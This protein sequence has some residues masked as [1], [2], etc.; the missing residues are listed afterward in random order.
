MLT[1]LEKVDLLRKSAMFCDVPTPG[2]ARVAAIA[3][4]ITFAPNQTLYVEDTVADSMFFLLEGEVE[5]V[6][7][8]GKI[9]TD[10]RGQVLGALALLSDETY[11]ESAQATQPTQVLRIDRQ[12]FF[13]TMAE[14]FD[15]T[16]GVLKALASVAAGGSRSHPGPRSL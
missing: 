11:T 15:V 1:V 9:G 4:A 16:R 3:S 10:R 12:E 13:D 6:H 5:L 7:S 2:L 14:D 8:G